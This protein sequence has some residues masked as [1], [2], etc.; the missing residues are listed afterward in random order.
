LAAVIWG[1]EKN[2]KRK[3]NGTVGLGRRFSFNFDEPWKLV[4]GLERSQ[5]FASH[6]RRESFGLVN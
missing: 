5:I 2:Q 3:F 4:E 6:T 1:I